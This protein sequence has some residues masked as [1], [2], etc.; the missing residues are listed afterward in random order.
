MTKLLVV[1]MA[2]GAASIPSRAFAAGE[3]EKLSDAEL[4]EVTGGDMPGFAFAFH[5]GHHHHGIDMANSTPT[6]IGTQIIVVIKDVTLVFNVGANSNV[7]LALVLQLALA[8][9]QP[10]VA[11]ATAL[12]QVGHH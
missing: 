4:D 2:F 11:A 1:A 8:S 10:Q 7:N 5:H 9:Q 6:V 3:P 12:Q